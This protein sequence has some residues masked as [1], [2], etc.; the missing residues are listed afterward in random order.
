M[1]L[2]MVVGCDQSQQLVNVFPKKQNAKDTN[3]GKITNGLRCRLLSEP[4]SPDS[5]LYPF[6][7]LVVEIENVGNNNIMIPAYTM[8]F[9]GPV[10][11]VEL[12]IAEEP[13]VRSPSNSGDPV[14]GSIEL[15]PGQLWRRRLSD[16]YILAF[17][18][19]HRN[20]SWVRFKPTRQTY[21]LSVKVQLKK[22]NWITSDTIVFTMPVEEEN[23][24]PNTTADGG[25]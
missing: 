5:D 4:L 19:W 10:P 16:G 3:W 23:A 6:K 9:N 13:E 7:A 11:L 12:L 17:G 18:T 8:S 1:L 21:H 2:F 24:E 20:T 14:L 15:K 25:E 22:Q